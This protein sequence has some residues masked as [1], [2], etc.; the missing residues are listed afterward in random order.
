[1][2][3]PSH[4]NRP[5]FPNVQQ[6]ERALLR[7]KQG[8]TTHVERESQ[9][10]Q[11]FAACQEKWLA[12]YEQVRMRIDALEARLAPWMNVDAGPQLSVVPRQEDAA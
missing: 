12:Q 2:F 8:V 6:M 4:A 11:M 7:L 3:V 9:L 1:M 5:M 10:H